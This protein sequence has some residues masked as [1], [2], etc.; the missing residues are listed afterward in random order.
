MRACVCV[1]VC[2]CVRV[3]VCVCVCGR[4]HEWYPAALVGREVTEGLGGTLDCAAVQR[5]A[6]RSL[7]EGQ[8]PRLTS[9]ACV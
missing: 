2:V 6:A 1:C 3:F 8:V 9:T 5:I 4:C 7:A